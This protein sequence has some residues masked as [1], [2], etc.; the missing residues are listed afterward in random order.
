MFLD[1]S[2]SSSFG[3]F[4]DEGL[5]AKLRMIEEPAKPFFSN[6]AVSDMF[7]R[8]LGILGAVSEARREYLKALA[9]RD[10]QLENH[11]TSI[12]NVAHAL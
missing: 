3:V 4:D 7:V 12:T 10:N 9:K 1:S 6:I 2:P 5:G 8:S 11:Q